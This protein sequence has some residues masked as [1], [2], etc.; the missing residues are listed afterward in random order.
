VE[1]EEKARLEIDKKLEDA[2]WK[3]VDR[4]EYSPSV[5]AM[6]VREGLLKGNKEADYLLFRDISNATDRQFS[7]FRLWNS[8]AIVNTGRDGA[9]HVSTLQTGIEREALTNLIQLVR[10]AF[11][12]IPELKSL[13]SFASSR[14]ELWCGQNQRPLTEQQKEIVKEIVGYIVANGSYTNNE[15]RDENITLFA[16]MVRSFVSPE[17]VDEVLGSLSW[18]ILKAA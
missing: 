8:Y 12:I 3:V 15:L 16:Q 2:G 7:M 11:Q 9:R 10:Y 6:A 4:D 18:V 1:P 13:S 14:F 17:V 5:S